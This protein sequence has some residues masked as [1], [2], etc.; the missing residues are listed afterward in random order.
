MV[1]REKYIEKIMEKKLNQ[2]PDG[3]AAADACRSGD[4]HFNL[5]TGKKEGVCAINLELMVPSVGASYSQQT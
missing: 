2:P 1:I 5:F 4:Q 3:T